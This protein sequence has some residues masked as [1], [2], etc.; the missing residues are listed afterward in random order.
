MPLVSKLTETLQKLASKGDNIPLTG[1]NNLLTRLKNDGVP[2]QEIETS[3]ILKLVENLNEAQRTTD[4]HTQEG[5]L[6]SIGE[7]EIITRTDRRTGK[8][9]QVITPKGLRAAERARKD[10]ELFRS[11]TLSTGGEKQKTEALKKTRS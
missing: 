6:L 8:R 1:N 11:V 4:P 3:G 7:P 10:T 5:Q 2:D 9:K